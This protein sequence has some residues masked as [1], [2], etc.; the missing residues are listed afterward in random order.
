MYDAVSRNVDVPSLTLWLLDPHRIESSL[1]NAPHPVNTIALHRRRLYTIPQPRHARPASRH[2][3]PLPR[4]RYNHPT[5]QDRGGFHL[6]PPSLTSSVSIFRVGTWNRPGKVKRG[7]GKTSPS[8]PVLLLHVSDKQDA[9]LLRT[10]ASRE[11]APDRRSLVQLV[12]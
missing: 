10:R 9:S 4:P 6:V 2:P 7:M 5:F 12:V 1:R 8:C 11:F 3:L